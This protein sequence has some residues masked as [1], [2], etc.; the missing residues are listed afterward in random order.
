MTDGG[1]G[2]TN[3]V[4]VAVVETLEAEIVLLSPFV[5]DV[6]GSPALTCRILSFIVPP[7]A[8]TFL[9]FSLMRVTL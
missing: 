3:S 9:S 2:K 7:G 1:V 6:P 5:I 4:N 8:P